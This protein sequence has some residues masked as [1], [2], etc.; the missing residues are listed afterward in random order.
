[1]FGIAA[2]FS[3][4]ILAWFRRGPGPITPDAVARATLKAASL[5][6]EAAR[7]PK[8]LGVRSWAGNCRVLGWKLHLPPRT[9][10]S[11]HYKACG[12]GPTSSHLSVSGS[13]CDV[14]LPRK[15][16][17]PLWHDVYAH[18]NHACH[19]VFQCFTF[20]FALMRCVCH[21]GLS[22][23]NRY[24]ARVPP[25]DEMR[26]CSCDLG[27]NILIACG[28]SVPAVSRAS[29]PK[30]RQSLVMPSPENVR[31]KAACRL[32]SPTLHP[33]GHSGQNQVADRRTDGSQSFRSRPD[34][35]PSAKGPTTVGAVGPRLPILEATQCHDI[36]IT[37]LRTRAMCV[38]PKPNSFHGPGSPHL[39]LEPLAWRTQSRGQPAQI[40]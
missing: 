35:L 33:C 25:I 8:T 31:M 16:Q 27:Q 13:S 19:R 14:P 18:K 24:P 39:S 12:M 30:T 11:T 7:R 36:M 5:S 10:R 17:S 32:R 28:L 6:K 20:A 4:R 23:A 29:Q 21:Q 9:P 2:H 22:S 37:A 40:R 34:P 1:M 38:A 26:G 3:C 15:A